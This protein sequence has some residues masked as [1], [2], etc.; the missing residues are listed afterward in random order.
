MVEFNVVVLFKKEALVNDDEKQGTPPQEPI[1]EI[2]E[3]E[4]VEEAFSL[5]IVTPR[6]VL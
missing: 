1:E 2:T 4:T 3:A 5:V 6:H